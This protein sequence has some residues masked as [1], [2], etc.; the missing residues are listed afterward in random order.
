MRRPVLFAYQLVTGLS[1]TLTGIALCAAPAFTL[2]MMGVRA[3]ADALPYISYIGAFVLSV[4]LACLYGARILQLPSS[5]ER[6]ETVWF[7]TALTRAAVALYLLPEI[8]IGNLQPAW[9]SVVVFDGT[10]AVI[11]AVG[12]RRGWLRDAR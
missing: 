6:I 12:L 5:L 11:Q 2:R 9:L 7:L 1:D 8:S 10:C 3:P 4:G